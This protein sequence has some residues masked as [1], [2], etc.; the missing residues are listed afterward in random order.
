MAFLAF[1]WRKMRLF[2]YGGS[3][4]LDNLLQDVAKHVLLSPAPS[5]QGEVVYNCLPEAK[6][7]H[8]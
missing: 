8:F 4:T 3:E 7:L 2:G 6:K 5:K 1:F